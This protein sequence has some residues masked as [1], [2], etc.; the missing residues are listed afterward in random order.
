M[1]RRLNLHGMVSCKR[2]GPGPDSAKE[3]AEWTHRPICC[4]LRSSGRLSC[5]GK[6]ATT[7]V[8]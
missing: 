2:R 4:F 3:R 6:D 5:S 8:V 1:P 7:A